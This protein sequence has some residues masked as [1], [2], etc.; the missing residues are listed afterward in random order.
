MTYATTFSGIGGWEIGLNACGWELKWQ[1]ERDEW[2][3]RLLNERFGVPIYDDIR[4]ICEHNPATVDALIGSPPCQPFS[5]AGAKGGTSDERHLFPA[6]AELVRALQPRWVLME[7]VPNVL[8]IDG[9]G[10]FAGY[11]GGLVAIGYSVVWH[12]IPACAIGA[13]HQRDRLWIVA[14][15]EH[16][17]LSERRGDCRVAKN[18]F[19]L[20][21]VS[22]D[23][24]EGGREQAGQVLANAYSAGP[25]RQGRRRYNWRSAC[26]WAFRPSGWADE[27]DWFIKS[28][29]GRVANGVPDRVHRLKALGNAVV[30]Q[31]PFIIGR[32]INQIESLTP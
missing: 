19:G 12:C 15:A 24:N 23:D 22:G 25:Q 27:A 14:H 28:G 16:G 29:M 26:E 6:F 2:C 4:T 32:A 10:A 1:C 7:Q 31:I 13:N 9:G 3:R 17:G 8:A 20:F 5:I 30:P 11:V 18:A 21:G